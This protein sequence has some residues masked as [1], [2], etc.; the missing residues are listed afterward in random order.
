MQQAMLR[1][2]IFG[3]LQVH[4]CGYPGIW[5]LDKP[6]WI[7]LEWDN[8]QDIAEIHLTF[9]DDVNEDLIN[10]HHHRTVFEAIPEIV[11]SYRIQAL[12]DQEWVTIAA[13]QD[14]HKRKKVHILGNKVMSKQIKI[15]IDSTNGGTRAEVTEIRVYG[16]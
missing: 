3:H 13:E 16:L 10:L 2:A 14:N 1:M 12:I 7:Q 5:P 6:E 15:W 11:R 4:I 8:E 9:N